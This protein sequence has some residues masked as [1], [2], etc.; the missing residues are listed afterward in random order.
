MIV[1]VIVTPKPSYLGEKRYLKMSKKDSDNSLL[2]RF[3]DV[4]PKE[5]NWFPGHMFKAGKQLQ[6]ILKRVDVV[7]ELRDARIP[8]ASVNLE[9]EKL[10]GEK[11]RLVLFNK[12]SLAE[13]ETIQDWGRYFKV[14]GSVSSSLMFWKKGG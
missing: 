13:E 5:I 1:S 7:L 12:T 14:Q 8:L 2:D 9:F 4:N 11:K 3:K 6:Q 10:L